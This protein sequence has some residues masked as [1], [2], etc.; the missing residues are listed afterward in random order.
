MAIRKKKSILGDLRG[1]IDS[2]VLSSWNDTSTVRS[3][4]GKRK[5]KTTS[6]KVAQQNS[7]FGM[8]S[9][10][11]RTAKLIINAGYQ[12]R[13]PVKMTPYNSALSYHLQHAVCGDPEDP[14]ISLSKVKLSAPVRTTQSAWNPV[15]SC[16]G[17]NEVT[18]KWDLNPFPQR[19]TQLDDKVILV[20]YDKSRKMFIRLDKPIVRSDVAWTEVM[21]NGYQGN[22][23]YWYMFMV[24]ADGKLVS[25]TT[26]LGMVT[27]QN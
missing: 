23:L 4:P 10:F 13:K 25:E 17:G 9:K 12:Q 15:L 21:P 26:Y 27:I 19:C 1:S 20:F 7:V 14:A 2:I 3:K 6:G 16:D 8:V 24:S 5:K 22:E 11:F 18:V